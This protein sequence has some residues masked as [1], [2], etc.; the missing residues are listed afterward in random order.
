MRGRVKSGARRVRHLPLVPAFHFAAVL[1][2]DGLVLGSDLCHNSSQ[3]DLRLRIH[4]HVHRA[5]GDLA[6]Q[7]G[8]L[9]QTEG[10]GLKKKCVQSQQ[11]FLLGHC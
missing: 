10:A 5:G 11:T 2:A 3:V 1:V 7:G 4:L 6:T 9:L 8:E